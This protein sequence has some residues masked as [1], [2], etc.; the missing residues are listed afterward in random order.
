MCLLSI[1][2]NVGNRA[3]NIETPTFKLGKKYLSASP[4][5]AQRVPYR[6]SKR[7]KS[8]KNHNIMLKIINKNR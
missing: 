7:R 6:I 1:I 8:V 5:R 4:T 2:T 3:D